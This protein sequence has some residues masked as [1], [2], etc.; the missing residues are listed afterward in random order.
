MGILD[1]F[2]RRLRAGV[3]FSKDTLVAIRKDEE[4]QV[5]RRTL[6]G[7]LIEP[8]LMD[9]NV[10]VIADLARILGDAL[11]ELGIRRESLVV[12]LPD[13]SL[14]TFVF[15]EGNSVH[16]RKL[17]EELN[18]VLPFSLDEARFD[19]WVGP[20]NEVLGSAIR[21]TVIKQYEQAIEAVEC[22]PGWVDGTSIVRIPDWSKSVLTSQGLDVR[23]QM[24]V[25]HYCLAIFQDGALV[26]FRT[27]LR[28][29]GALESIQREVERIPSLYGGTKIRSI[30]AYGVDSESLSNLLACEASESDETHIA[31]ILKILCS[32]RRP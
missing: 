18:S 13:L 8:S 23:V 1:A 16:R 26:D 14:A 29:E 6:P 28:Q 7:G 9:L 15:S 25:D 22:S 17:S 3:V 2:S 19:F 30:H 31:T 12:G 11:E 27:K 4:L 10:G 5:V 20:K 24:Y 32:R 21:T